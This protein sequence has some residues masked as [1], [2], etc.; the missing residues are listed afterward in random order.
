MRFGDLFEKW[1]LTGLKIN[2]GILEM[3]WEPADIDK[4]AAW[5]LYV[6]LLTRVATQPLP[7]AAGVEATALESIHKLFPIT[8]ETLKHHGR[9]AIGFSRVAVI[10]LNQI[11]RPFTAKWH[12]LSQNDGF[13]DPERCREF[14]SELAKLR[15]QLI[16][17]S[18]LLAELAAVEDLTEIDADDRGS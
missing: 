12:A 8:R 1:D 5:D 11:V 4:N 9:K 3:D 6:E 10:V 7:D 17:Y 14:R 18:K 16:Q 2:A 15:T 13:A